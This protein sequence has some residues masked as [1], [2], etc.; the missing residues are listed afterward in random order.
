MTTNKKKGINDIVAEGGVILKECREWVKTK[1][2]DTYMKE[3][4]IRNIKQ[5][6]S[7]DYK[8]MY[9][10]MITDDDYRELHKKMVKDHHDFA[11]IYAIVVRHIVMHNEYFDDAMRRYVQYLTN[12]PW[13]EKKEFIERQGEYLVHVERQKNPRIGTTQLAKYRDH[14]RK[15][16]LEEDEKFDEY[17]KEVKETVNKEWD[18]IIANRKQR[19]HDILVKLKEEAGDTSKQEGKTLTS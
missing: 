13:K 1:Y 7:Q 5:V 17:E 18:E 12:N 9:A 19:L 8:L 3:R 16:L 14:V 10:T 11:S 15:Q 6:T 4:G 2:L